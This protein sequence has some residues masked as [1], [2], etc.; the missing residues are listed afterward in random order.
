[1]TV[2]KTK[3]NVH[4]ISHNG[5]DLKLL[6]RESVLQ[7]ANKGLCLTDIDKQMPA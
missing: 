2:A 7:S 3:S 4:N 1:M 6:I 5:F